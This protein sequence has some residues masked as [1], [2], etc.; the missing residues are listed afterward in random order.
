MQMLDRHDCFTCSTISIF[1]TIS[2][3]MSGSAQKDR[4][5]KALAGFSKGT[6]LRVCRQYS[7]KQAP[8]SHGAQE[9][10]KGKLAL[11]EKR[12]LVLALS[13]MWESREHPDPTGY[14]RGAWL[15]KAIKSL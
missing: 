11:G 8:T 1:Q 15:P 9:E 7:K 3:N 12:F 10:L 4:A 14:Q 6:S 5:C 2:K 13:H